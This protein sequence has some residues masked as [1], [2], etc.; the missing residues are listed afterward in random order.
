MVSFVILYNPWITWP[1]DKCTFGSFTDTNK[2][3]WKVASLLP[4]FLLHGFC[5]SLSLHSKSI[6]LPGT[7]R[8][9]KGVGGFSYFFQT[10]YGIT[11]VVIVLLSA[12]VLRSTWTFGN[13]NMFWGG[14]ATFLLAFTLWNIGEKKCVFIPFL[15]KHTLFTDSH[16]CHGLESFREKSSMTL[17]KPFSQLHGWWHILTGGKNITLFIVIL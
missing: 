9:I 11:V 2:R 13:K 15:T 14:L 8:T 3:K 6:S 12:N 7:K 1:L 17:L 5:N 4:L 16:F 10:M